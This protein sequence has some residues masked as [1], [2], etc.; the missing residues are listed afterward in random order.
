MREFHTFRVGFTPTNR[1]PILWTKALQFVF[2]F[3]VKE[4]VGTAVIGF[5]HK[6]PGR[7]TQI[8]VIRHGGI[9]ELLPGRDTMLFK[10]RHKHLGIDDRT[11][12]KQF[13]AGNLTTDGNR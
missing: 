12:I 2:P 7:T 9:H 11:G 10:H 8:A 5:R 3:G 1:S 6:N 13:H 4:L